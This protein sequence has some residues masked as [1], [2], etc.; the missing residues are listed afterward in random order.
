MAAKQLQFDENARHALLRGI[1]DGGHARAR[2][3]AAAVGDRHLRA[4]RT[5]D[6]EA[7]ALEAGGRHRRDGAHRRRGVA[8][9]RI[10]AAHP[11]LLP[12]R[13][14]QARADRARVGRRRCERRPV[15]SCDRPRGARRGCA[16][17]SSCRGDNACRSRTR[18]ATGLPRH[19][20]G[21]GQR[22]LGEPARRG[23]VDG[24]QRQLVP[25]G[26]E[27]RAGDAARACSQVGAAATAAE[28]SPWA[29]RN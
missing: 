13:R 16:D 28:R 19:V 26:R 3:F 24:R 6:A 5:R 15:A 8:N 10:G 4:R 14:R 2:A 27:R 18:P 12:D 9:A 20:A 7:R 22:L 29:A 23:R 11:R 25:E 1:G 17:R 21:R